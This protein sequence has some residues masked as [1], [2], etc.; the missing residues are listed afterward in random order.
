VNAVRDEPKTSEQTKTDE[1][2]SLCLAIRIAPLAHGNEP[3]L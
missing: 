2:E 3:V 1:P